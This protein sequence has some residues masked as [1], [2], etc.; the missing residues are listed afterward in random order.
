[1]DWLI[2]RC[3][4]R[5]GGSTSTSTSTSTGTSTSSASHGG[6]DPPL[7]PGPKDALV[8]AGD[9]SHRLETIERSLSV[10]SDNLGC[11]TF[12][13]PGNHEAWVGGKEMDEMGLTSSFDK[14]QRVMDVC[15]RLGVHT[16]HKLVGSNHRRPAWIVPIWSWYD[17][18]LAL[19]GC[20]DLCDGFGQWPWVDFARCKWGEEFLGS[21]DDQSSRGDSRFTIPGFER[22]PSQ[23]L[24]KKMLSRND[25]SVATVKEH[26]ERCSAESRDFPGLISMTHFSPC[27]ATL[28]DWKDP[29]SD[30]FL[31]KEWLDHSA[32]E[33]S[34]KFAYVSGSQLI[35]DQIRSMSDDAH[36]HLHVFG[37]SHRPKDFIRAGI[38]Y[39]HNPVGKPV[40]REMNMISKDFDFKLVWDAT[41]YDGEISA[42]TL[43][44]YW[45]EQGGG[46]EMLSRNLSKRERRRQQ[47]MKRRTK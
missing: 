38:R 29:S 30:T 19:P 36:R 34:A 24:V 40:E 17:G 42:P 25:G 7:T 8:I 23:R 5:F 2:D 9:I 28:P 32:P 26:L 18:T 14:L 35:D 22:I 31:R 1:M 41:T 45:E 47:Q 3:T 11:H 10:I 33:V 6:F 39:V 12:F 44:R 4:G 15:D 27:R 43:V 13:V 21:V 20:E 46:L 37:H 16:K